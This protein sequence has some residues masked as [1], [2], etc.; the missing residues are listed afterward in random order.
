MLLLLSSLLVLLLVFVSII[1]ITIIICA[2]HFF[3]I[4]YYNEFCDG[5]EIN[6]PIGPRDA[7]PGTQAG[8]VAST[9]EQNLIGRRDQAK[10]S[11]GPAINVPAL[12]RYNVTLRHLRVLKTTS[13]Y[14]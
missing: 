4:S 9:T 11:V 10:I 5:E 6:W 1:I 14:N 13:T 2:H 3:R 8:V 12:Q 7:F